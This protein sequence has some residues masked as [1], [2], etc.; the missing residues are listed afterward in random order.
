MKNTQP[1]IDRDKTQ[2]SQLPKLQLPKLQPLELEHLS[3]VAGGA[4]VPCPDC[5]E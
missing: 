2:T 4:L 3:C 1:H 5:P